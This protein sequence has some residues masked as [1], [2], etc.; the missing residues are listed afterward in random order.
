MALNVLVL[1]A[2]GMLGNAV[3]RVLSRECGLNVFGTARGGAKSLPFVDPGHGLALH[4]VLD[5]DAVRA[6]VERTQ[7]DV[8]INAVGVVKQLDSA[9]DPLVALPI[10]AMLP[11]QLARLCGE[12]GAR[13]IHVS[14][15]CV[16]DGKAGHYT[17]DATANATDLYGR[18]KL[19]GEVDYPN[20]ITL[21]TSIVGHELGTR[22]GLI[23]WFLAQEG[24]VFGY[25]KAIFS[26]LTTVEL[27]DVIARHV[28]P[29]PEL[30]GLFHVSVDPISKYDLL[31]LVAQ[32]YGKAIEI[33]PKDL[34]MIDRSLDSARFRAA[35]GY[36]PPDWP[37]LISSLR[38]VYQNAGP[39]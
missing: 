3:M 4:D 34:P 12:L 21:R 32:I 14:T 39:P 9:E 1:G 10:N 22:H 8:V 35:T 15:D 19:L 17:E 33:V 26:G 11:H 28:I 29:R 25:T 23:N 5:I 30:H 31:K 16:F 7:A 18:S 2:T 38:A 24:S 6:L 27:A 36:V 37:T 20:A 13:F